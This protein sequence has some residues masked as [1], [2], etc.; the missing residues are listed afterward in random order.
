M[1]SDLSAGRIVSC[2]TPL[3]EDSWKLMPGFIQTL[4]HVPFPIADFALYPF[5]VINHSCEY[6]SMLSPVSPSKSPNLGVNLGILN[7]W[8]A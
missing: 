4:L 8:R 5:A 2:V 3:R 1:L 7:S 6:N